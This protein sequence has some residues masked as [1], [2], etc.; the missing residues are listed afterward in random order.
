MPD[1]YSIPPGLKRQAVM[2]LKRTLKD[3]KVKK[4]IKKP[5]KAEKVSVAMSKPKYYP[6]GL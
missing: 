3:V 6:H 1:N 2:E 5:T 4:P